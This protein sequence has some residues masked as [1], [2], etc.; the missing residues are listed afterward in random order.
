MIVVDSSVIA[1]RN[2][3][4]GLTSKALKVE[5][6]DALWVVPVLWR[7][8]FQNILTTAVKAGHIDLEQALLSLQKVSSALSENEFES[9]PSW[10]FD[11]VS[12]YKITAYD[13]QFISLAME[14]GVFFVTEDRELQKKFPE[15]AFSMEAFLNL[16]DNSGVSEKRTRYQRM[17]RR[18]S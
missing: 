13:A 5:E 12:R 15:I 8:E 7:Y 14:M 17:K 11:L 10:V 6:K 9:S 1:A 2:L 16:Q 4:N 3:T 18:R